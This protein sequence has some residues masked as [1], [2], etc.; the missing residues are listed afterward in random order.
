[1]AD[2]VEFQQ[3][4]ETI[5]AIAAQADDTLTMLAIELMEI[6]VKVAKA[7]GTPITRESICGDNVRMQGIWDQLGQ[8]K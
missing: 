5:K 4:K 7:T 6:S 3:H 1:M 8:R 2:S